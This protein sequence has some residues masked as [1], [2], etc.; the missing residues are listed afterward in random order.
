MKWAV[1]SI[2]VLIGTTSCSSKKSASS[3]SPMEDNDVIVLESDTQDQLDSELN[4]FNKYQAHTVY[5]DGEKLEEFKDQKQI[6]VLDQVS[7]NFEIYEVQPNETLMII[8][9]KIFGKMTMWKNLY[10]WNEDQLVNESAVSAGMK[11]KYIPPTEPFYFQ[12]EG[13]PY[14]ILRGETLSLISK[15]VYEGK[16]SYWKKIYQNNKPMIKDPNLIYAGFTLY[17]L[18]LEKLNPT[19]S[20]RDLAG[21][22]EV[23]SL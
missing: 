17:Y 13:N 5:D 21:N 12:P 14:L 6:E 2:L 1:L 22:E 9:F 7:N 10:A 11:I 20:Q 23:N 3:E 16:M 4:S 18:P 19:E 15:K 8:S